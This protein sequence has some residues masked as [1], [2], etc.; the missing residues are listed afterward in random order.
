MRQRREA[1]QEE[2]GRLIA[3]VAS[4]GHSP[5]LVKAINDREQ[6]LSEISRKA[7]A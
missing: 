3:A 1:I 2:R 6:G 4:V 7:L 5:A